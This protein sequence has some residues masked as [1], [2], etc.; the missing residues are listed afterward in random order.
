VTIIFVL[1]A[2]ESLEPAEVGR[3]VI[4]TA[5]LTVLLSVMAHGLTAEPLA[6]RYGAW[7]TRDRPAVELMDAA[8]PQ[9]RRPWRWRKEAGAKP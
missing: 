5:A 7:V 9:V 2:L 4:A 8:E 1:I 6:S 3:R